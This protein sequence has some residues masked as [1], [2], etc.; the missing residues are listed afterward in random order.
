MVLKWYFS[1]P[2]TIHYPLLCI[3]P[4]YEIAN[5]TAPNHVSWKSPLGQQFKIHTG[6]EGEIPG[7]PLQTHI[8]LRKVFLIVT[9]GLWTEAYSY[10]LNFRY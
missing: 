1:S 8:V 2:L 3:I 4:V 7:C 5:M 6:L 10:F 9:D